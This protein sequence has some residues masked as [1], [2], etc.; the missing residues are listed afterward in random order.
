MGLKTVL[1]WH[2][3]SQRLETHLESLVDFSLAATFTTK[4]W[5]TESKSDKPVWQQNNTDCYWS[6]DRHNKLR[7]TNASKRRSV[8]SHQPR[9]QTHGTSKY[10]NWF[11]QC[12][13]NTTPHGCFTAIS[14]QQATPHEYHSFEHLRH[15]MFPAFAHLLTTQSW[16]LVN[17]KQNSCQQ[18]LV[19]VLIHMET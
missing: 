12:E 16:T 7:R 14:N 8:T 19:R 6:R 10:R 15:T 9:Y 13:S 17:Q 1:E 11:C 18:S 3:V 4:S 2:Q 5:T